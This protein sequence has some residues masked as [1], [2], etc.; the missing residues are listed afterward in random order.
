MNAIE[1]PVWVFAESD[2]R[3]VQ[4]VSLELIGHARKLAGSLQV[5][6]E[7]IF[8]GF[9]LSDNTKDLQKFTLISWL[10]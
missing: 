1:G 9:N 8:L 10:P 2:A 7:V 6:L 3:G 4:S 5:D